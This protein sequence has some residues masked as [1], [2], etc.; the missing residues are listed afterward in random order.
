[1]DRWV[2]ALTAYY[3]CSGYCPDRL[4]G[5][6]LGDGYIEGVDYALEIE[7]DLHIE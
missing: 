1:M 3:C 5:R 6:K 4:F 2:F 7:G